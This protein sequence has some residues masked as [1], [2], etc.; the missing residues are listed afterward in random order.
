MYPVV[1]QSFIKGQYFEAIWAFFRIFG[2]SLLL[3]DAELLYVSMVRLLWISLSYSEYNP[4]FC[5]IVFK[6]SG[7]LVFR[8][9]PSK[10]VKPEIIT[11]IDGI[12]MIIELVGWTFPVIVDMAG[13]TFVAIEWTTEVLWRFTSKPRKWKKRSNPPWADE[14]IWHLSIITIGF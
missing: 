7:K 2:N 1:Q 10:V 11:W 13:N 4:S 6:T 3:E 5:T 12:I 14:S 9:K 8:F